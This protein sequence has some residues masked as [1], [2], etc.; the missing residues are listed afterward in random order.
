MAK[1]WIKS[2]I[3]RPGAL[4]M[5]A[6]AAGMTPM[7]YAKKMKGAK[8][9]TGKQARLAITLSKMRKRKK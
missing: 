1:R 6:K 5:K 2:A 3:K 7:T 9:T 8:G 4:T